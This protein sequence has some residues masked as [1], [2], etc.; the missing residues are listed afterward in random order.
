V[1]IGRE[2]LLKFACVTDGAFV[3]FAAIVEY[4]THPPTLRCRGDEDRATQARRRQ[5]FVRAITAKADVAVELAE[6]SWAD[7]SLML[8]LLMLAR[9]MRARG[10]TLLLRDA[11]PQI[12]ALLELVGLDRLPGVELEH[13]PE[14]SAAPALA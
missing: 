7:A 10:H 9:R 2:S 12:L 3:R 5:A 11:Q 13:A 1:Y 6:L 4:V 8:D 14:A